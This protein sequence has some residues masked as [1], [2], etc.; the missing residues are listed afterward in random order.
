MAGSFTDLSLYFLLPVW[1]WSIPVCSKIVLLQIPG[2][3]VVTIAEVHSAVFTVGT[4]GS[5]YWA[6]FETKV[7]VLIFLPGRL[8]YPKTLGV[9]N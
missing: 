8:F 6:F 1:A 5:S 9:R 2:G 7:F 3:E 4:Q